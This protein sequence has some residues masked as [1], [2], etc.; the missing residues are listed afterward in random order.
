MQF[1]NRD[2]K[3]VLTHEDTNPTENVI[4]VDFS[5]IDNV[6]EEEEEEEEETWPPL[7]RTIS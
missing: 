5:F 2:K 3:S 4:R 7:V 1:H 6:Q